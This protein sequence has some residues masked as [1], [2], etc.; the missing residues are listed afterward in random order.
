VDVEEEDEDNNTIMNSSDEGETYHDSDNSYTIDE[1]DE[2]FGS[3]IHDTS[4]CNDEDVLVEQ[5]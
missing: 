3:P 4:S 1:D 2:S 5:I